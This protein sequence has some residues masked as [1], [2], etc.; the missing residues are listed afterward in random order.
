MK[1]FKDKLFGMVENWKETP[2]MEEERKFMKQKES[3][4]KER[5]VEILG[6]KKCE[7]NPDNRPEE[8]MKDLPDKMTSEDNLRRLQLEEDDPGTLTQ[9]KYVGKSRPSLSVK[10]LKRTSASAPSLRK[11]EDVRKTTFNTQEDYINIDDKKRTWRNSPV[12]KSFV[13]TIETNPQCEAPG[14]TTRIY[15]AS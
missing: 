10:L 9:E 2:G 6:R 15:T 4:I 5:I 7:R 8:D 13:K 3:A 11:H 12:A 1:E 14:R